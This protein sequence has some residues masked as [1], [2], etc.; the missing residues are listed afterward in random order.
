MIVNGLRVSTQTSYTYQGIKGWRRSNSTVISCHY[1][2][3]GW[4]AYEGELKNVLG[5]RSGWKQAQLLRDRGGVYEKSSTFHLCLHSAETIPQNTLIVRWLSYPD[6]NTQRIRSKS[7]R[8]MNRCNKKWKEAWIADM[9]RRLS[10]S[11][12]SLGQLLNLSTMLQEI[13]HGCD[14]AIDGTMLE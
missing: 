11:C 6:S 13:T 7:P 14:P 5:K 4:G 12:R 3:L 2:S 8:T 9:P 10:G 1:W